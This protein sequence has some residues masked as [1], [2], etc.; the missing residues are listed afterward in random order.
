MALTKSFRETVQARAA[1]DPAFRAGLYQEAVQAMLDGDG[2]T[3]RALVRDFINATMGLPALAAQ[4]GYVGHV[5]DADAGAGREPADGQPGGH[6]DSRG[7]GA[8]TQAYI[9][10]A[11]TMYRAIN[12]GAVQHHMAPLPLPD[13]EDS[14]ARRAMVVVAGC[15]L[16]PSAQYFEAVSYAYLELRKAAGLSVAIPPH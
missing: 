6:A 4:L 3:G 7:C 11:D 2:V 12:K 15:K 8:D 9:N 16:N 14:E 1:L 10:L 5:A 13:D